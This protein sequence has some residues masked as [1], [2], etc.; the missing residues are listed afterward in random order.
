MARMYAVDFR[1][2]LQLNLT[3]D[4]MLFQLDRGAFPQR[5]DIFLLPCVNSFTYY[6]RYSP[7]VLLKDMVPVILFIAFIFIYSL[8]L[9]HFL[10]MS[11]SCPT[12]LAE[13]KPR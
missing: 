8:S 4:S 6:L 10:H 12:P 2:Q 1:L 3:L 7:S 5:E 11:S 13:N 9:V